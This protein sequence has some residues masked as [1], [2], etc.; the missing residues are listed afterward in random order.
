[1]S[2]S[3]RD[4]LRAALPPRTEP[5][6]PWA[7]S[8]RAVARVKNPLPV[9]EKCPHC[10]SPVFI[11]SNSCIYGRE[12]GEWPWALMCTGCDSYV[13]LHPFTG[14]P[15]GTLATPEMRRARSAA[16]DAFNPLWQDGPMTR[17]D[18]YA[19]LASALGI[20]DVEQCHI[21]WFDVAQCAAVVA[22]V[23]ARTT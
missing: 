4:Q 9:P 11:D 19:W 23:K 13:G 6:S 17:S 14:I 18:A 5:V 2:R 10:G 3:M 7:P 1:M 16:K 20:A 22:A 12:Y 21:A 8:R 15:L